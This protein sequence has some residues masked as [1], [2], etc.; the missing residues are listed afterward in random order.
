ML[1]PFFLQ[2]SKTE[3]GLVQ[4]LINEQLK[5]YGVEIYYIPRQ[6]LT[7]NTVIEEVIESEF[8]NASPIEAY[9]NTYDGYGGQGTILSKF[10]VQDIDEL[11]VTISKERYDTQVSPL[12]KN[13]EGSEYLGRPR[14]GDLIYFPLGKRLFEIKYVEHEK[15]FYQLQKNY[16]YELRCEL[17]RY[18][19]EVID[20]GLDKIDD[21]VDS[22][23]YI[24]TL[25]VIG[26]GIT[27]T[28]TCT[29]VNGG[30]K[31]VI[32]SNRGLNYTSI[33]EVKFSSAPQSGLTAS[34]IAT[35]IGDIVDFCGPDPDTFRVQ[36]V[37]IINSGYGYTTPPSVAFIGGGGSGAEAS[38]IISDGVI[39]EFIIVNGGSGY[40]DEPNVTISSP[41]SGL[42]TATARAIVGSSGTI[43][44][45]VIT[46]AGIGYTTPPTITISPPTNTGIGTFI[47]NETITGSS[48]GT[49]ALVKRW[50]GTNNKLDVYKITGEFRDYETIVGSKSGAQYK[51]TEINSNNI[52]DTF[53]QNYDIENESDQILDFSESNP[54]G[55]P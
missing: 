13:F 8:N 35:M 42:S 24:Q 46:D 40:Y 29:I 37:N 15:P 4:D 28:A 30:V 45:I 23:G 27:A 36:G 47:V 12:S 22:D 7:I 31:S 14:E 10:G 51:L 16:V 6:Y 43:S 38:T 53:A 48:T 55:N 32:V 5:I 20:T 1:N 50:D 54:F 17:F 25:N 41:P 9:V 34:G 39:G 26:V 44:N 33:P 11:V 19:D 18:E 52:R 49:T 2:G 3:Q 21:L